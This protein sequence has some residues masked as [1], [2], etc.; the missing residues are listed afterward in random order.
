MKTLTLRKMGCNFMYDSDWNRSDCGNYRL[1][2]EF[3]DKDGK[4]IT[5][6]F[7][8]CGVWNSLSIDACYYD[9]NNICR[10]YT[11]LEKYR[12][13]TRHIG[14]K[15]AEILLAVNSVSAEQYDYVEVVSNDIR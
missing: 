15:L 12:D 2:A 4:K 10:T 14:Y 13:G 5:A 9:K 8:G 3:T 11:T 1:R 7:S 6:D